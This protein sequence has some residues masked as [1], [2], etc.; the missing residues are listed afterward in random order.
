MP[1]SSFGSAVGGDLLLG[2]FPSTTLLC[3]SAQ[4]GEAGL[5]DDQHRPGTIV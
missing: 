4:G 5:A 2:C 1:A 3:L